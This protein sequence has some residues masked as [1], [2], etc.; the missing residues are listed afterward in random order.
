MPTSVSQ[1]T[2]APS[3]DPVIW[4]EHRP[5]AGAPLAPGAPRGSS[6]A[7]PEDQQHHA[8]EDDQVPGPEHGRN[9]PPARY[10]TTLTPKLAATAA[11]SAGSPAS[12]PSLFA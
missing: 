11:S 9:V 8:G 4:N 6:S 12:H 3:I 1:G 2:A 7:C 10:S 5:S